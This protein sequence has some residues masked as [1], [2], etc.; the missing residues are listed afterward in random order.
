MQN[1]LSCGTS[2][3]SNKYEGRGHTKRKEEIIKGKPSSTQ[4]V[5]HAKS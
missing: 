2:F 3:E 4:L 1:Q 5:A